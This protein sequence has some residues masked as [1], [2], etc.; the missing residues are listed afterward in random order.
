[1]KRL[2]L[3]LHLIFLFMLHRLTTPYRGL[4]LQIWYLALITLVNRA[5]AMV[6]PFLSLYLNKQLHFS[7]DNIGWIMTAFGLGSAL[8]TFTGGKLTDRL[9]YLKV[10][11]TSLLLTGFMF[12]VLQQFQTFQTLVLGVFL[13]SFL[14]DTYRP[15]IWVAMDAYSSPENRTRSVT[16]IRLAI[17]LGFAVGPAMGGLII[18]HIGYAYLFWIDGLTS[19]VAAFLLWK[20]IAQKQIRKSTEEVQSSNRIVQSPYK[21]KPYLIF[22]LSIMFMGIAF[23]QFNSTMPVFFS[24]EVG[25]NEQQIGLLI[26]LNGLLIFLLEMPLVHFLEKKQLD[27]LV[28]TLFGGA[29]MVV[30]FLVLNLGTLIMFPV[31]AMV[32]LTFGEMISFPFSNTFAMQRAQR[33]LKGAYMALY[34]LTFSFAHIFGP[35]IGMHLSD[36]FGFVVTWYVMAGIMLISGILMGW[37]IQVLKKE[38]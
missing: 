17:N 9:G 26:A 18:A 29:L 27:P 6:I 19:I 34:T 10:M 30:T 32:L 38:N 2:F 24:K 31:L 21:D 22:F 11:V 36:R 14:A 15:A 37:V 1:M 16:L 25:M 20:L 7:L 13:L 3:P 5:G 23:M 28:V 35:N 12:F 4:S 8:G 33:G